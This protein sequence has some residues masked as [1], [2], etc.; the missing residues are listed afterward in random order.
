MVDFGADDSFEKA[1]EKAR[2]HYGIEVPGERS[3]KR[4]LSMPRL[5]GDNPF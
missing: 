2:E 4:P 1:A 5:F 3:E